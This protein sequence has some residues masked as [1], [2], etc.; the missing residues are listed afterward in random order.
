MI[1]SLRVELNEGSV[2]A[3]DAP[4]EAT[5]SGPFHVVLENYGG[6]VHVYLHFDDD[7]STVARIEEPN[8]YV[9]GGDT[10][11]V[12]VGVVTN[13]APAS[14]ELEIVS[15]YGAESARV[16]VT[17]EEDDPATAD[18]HTAGAAT[19]EAEGIPA[20]TTRGSGGTVSRNGS[21]RARRRSRSGGS[22]R[23]TATFFDDTA[24]TLIAQAGLD[25][26]E[27]LAF[28]G[29]VV[30]A[31]AVGLAVITAV[32]EILLSILT[33][34]IVTVAVAVAGWLLVD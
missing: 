22:A 9:E 10:N 31:L 18:T 23:A 14:G 27:G 29:V 19:D 3:I 11:R 28:L 8:H 21:R 24:S 17:I 7:L 16:D 12:P 32:G 25:S 15:G 34:A 26:R 5:V 4:A 20:T 6:P 30:I 33:V 2:H 1:T 13:R